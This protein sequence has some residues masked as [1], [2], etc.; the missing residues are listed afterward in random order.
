MTNSPTIFDLFVMSRRGDLELRIQKA[1]ERMERREYHPSG[2]MHGSPAARAP[3]PE[4]DRR[5]VALCQDLIDVM[6]RHS[7]PRG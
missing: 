1:R 4:A 6:D 3:S 7:S 2:L 5:M